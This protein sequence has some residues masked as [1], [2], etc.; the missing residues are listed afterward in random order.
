[1]MIA[2]YASRRMLDLFK[3]SFQL[4]ELISCKPFLIACNT[5]QPTYFVRIDCVLLCSYRLLKKHNDF[6]VSLPF[7]RTDKT[8]NTTIDINY[9]Q[10][11][12]L[13]KHNHSGIQKN[14]CILLTLLTLTHKCIDRHKETIDRKPNAYTRNKVHCS[15]LV[16]L[17]VCRI[18]RKQIIRITHSDLRPYKKQQRFLWIPVFCIHSIEALRFQLWPIRRRIADCHF[19]LCQFRH[20]VDEQ[21]CVWNR[22]RVCVC[23]WHLDFGLQNALAALRQSMNLINNLLGN[24]NINMRVV[25]G[26]ADLRH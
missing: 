13:R 11:A 15:P 14:I 24:W 16:Y 25:N 7:K 19:C 23:V 26:Y 3:P 17:S 20:F 18:K 9:K 2:H 10:T 8:F 22:G 4:N 5:F 6:Y 21:Y 12:F 1:M